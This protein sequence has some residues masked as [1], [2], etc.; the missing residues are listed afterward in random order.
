M[1]K[2]KI[3]IVESCFRYR[4]LP[5]NDKVLLSKLPN[6]FTYLTGTEAAVSKF[7]IVTV[8]DLLSLSTAGAEY[9]MGRIDRNGFEDGFEAAA[10]SIKGA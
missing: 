4:A 9:V 3:E 10:S 6:W 7:K 5:A 1:P 2:F 8:V